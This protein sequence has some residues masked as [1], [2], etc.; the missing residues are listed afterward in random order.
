MNALVR[1]DMADGRMT[2]GRSTTRTKLRYTMS[3]IN[4]TRDAEDAAAFLK[5]RRTQ[6]WAEK[7]VEIFITDPEKINIQLSGTP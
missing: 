6:A 5:S 7:Y 1:E 4:P 2:S 3:W